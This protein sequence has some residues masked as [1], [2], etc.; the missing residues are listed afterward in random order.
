MGEFKMVQKDTE[1]DDFYAAENVLTD[2]G[3]DFSDHLIRAANY[4]LV[5]YANE[6]FTLDY[7]CSIYIMLFELRNSQNWPWFDR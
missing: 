5:P 7:G 4:W 6:G 2:D 3:C 1:V